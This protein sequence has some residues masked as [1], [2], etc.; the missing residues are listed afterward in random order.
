MKR[1]E[2][3]LIKTL[4]F[5]FSI[6]L[7]SMFALIVTQVILRYCFN[8]SIGGANELAT[9]LFAYTSAFGVAVAI[10]RREHMSISWFVM[11]LSPGPRKIID[12]VGLFL[13]A[14]LNVTIFCY[15]IKWIGTTGSGMISVLQ[16]PRWTS[17]IAIPI[18][19]G[20]SALFC[21]IKL[22]LGIRGEEELGVPWTQ[23]D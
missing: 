22:Y 3:I 23:E 16:V 6:C 9:I 4:E 12:G 20:A 18:G 5:I 1:F 11:R 19:T 17:Q 14:A 7:L 13:L 8:W 2:T 21:F 10:A 15:S